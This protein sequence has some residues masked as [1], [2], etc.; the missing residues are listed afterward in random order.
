MIHKG[1]GEYAEAGEYDHID[2]VP[3][4]DLNKFVEGWCNNKSSMPSVMMIAKTD[5]GWQT[6]DNSEGMECNLEEFMHH[7]S[8]KRYLN[9][10][11]ELDDCIQVN[12]LWV[13][14]AISLIPKY[15]GIPL[16]EIANLDDETKYRL[17]HLARGYEMMEEMLNGKNNRERSE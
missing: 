12:G 1:L 14:V 9:R 7:Y 11:I 3:L 13:E 17:S 4:D 6:L 16:K 15:M 5:K 10:G 8:A 2:I